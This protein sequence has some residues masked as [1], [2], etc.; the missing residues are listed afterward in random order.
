[1]KK[2]FL[3]LAAVVVSG[4][5]AVAA[6][7]VKNAAASVPSECL[8]QVEGTTEWSWC[9]APCQYSNKCA[10]DTHGHYTIIYDADKAY[11]RN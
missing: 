4:V 2:K 10:C 6:S 8:S 5:A 1:M 11:W 9:C 3:I 7:N